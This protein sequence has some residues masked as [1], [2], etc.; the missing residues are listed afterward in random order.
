MTDRLKD[1]WINLNKWKNEN[2]PK[3]TGVFT[4]QDQYAFPVSEGSDN[5]PEVYSKVSDLKFLKW[6]V[7]L[8]IAQPC[9]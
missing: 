4:S 7:G 3:T 5:T 1:R 2:S 8:P 6:T 9:H